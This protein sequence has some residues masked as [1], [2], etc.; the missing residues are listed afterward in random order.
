M[1]DQCLLCHQN[2]LSQGVLDEI[3]KSIQQGLE[4]CKNLN[5]KHL[6]HNE[7]H[8]QLYNDLLKK[9]KQVKKIPKYIQEKNPIVEE[10]F[11][12]WAHDISS[13]QTDK[14]FQEKKP[15]LIQNVSTM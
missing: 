15:L 9:L 6:F 2:S 4:E 13:L 7:K 8:T 10:R 14:N 3:E 12:K 1:L 11:P 5:F